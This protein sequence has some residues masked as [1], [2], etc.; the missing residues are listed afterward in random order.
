VREL[1]AEERLR[2]RTKKKKRKKKVPTIGDEPL[3]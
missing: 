1:E 3:A 2:Q